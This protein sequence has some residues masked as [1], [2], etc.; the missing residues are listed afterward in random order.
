MVLPPLP[1]K[2]IYTQSGGWDWVNGISIISSN[3]TTHTSLMY[4]SLALT[5]AFTI[6]VYTF[7]GSLDARQKRS[8]QKTDFPKQLETTVAKIDAQGNGTTQQSSSLSK[9]K[10]ETTT[11]DDD[12][13]T[14]KDTTTDK[15]LLQQLQDKFKSS[16]SYG[17]DKINFGMCASTYDTIESVTF[18]LIGF[19]PY[20][21]DVATSLGTRYFGYTQ[22][23]EIKNS[24]VF[25]LLVTLVGTIT[26]LP[27]ELY[28]TFNIE[29]RH[30][31]NKQT[32]GLFFSDKVKS[33]ILTFVIGGPFIALLL[34]IIKVRKFE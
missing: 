34:K 6:L 18:L 27:F 24:L 29:K 10:K 23:D 17:L 15:P 11:E 19:L 1:W 2:P 26:S 16:Q 5:V 25:L 20:M 22:E 21:W 3:D 33:L 7:E 9:K 4:W 14:K 30:G 28:S 13:A 32:Y 31:F 12:D 8:Y